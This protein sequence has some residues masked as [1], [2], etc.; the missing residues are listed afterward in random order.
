MLFLSQDP[1]LQVLSFLLGLVHS[2]VFVHSFLVF[3]DP[4]TLKEY[5]LAISRNVIQFG[6]V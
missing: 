2:V 6:F 5:Q 4:D 3:H 1:R